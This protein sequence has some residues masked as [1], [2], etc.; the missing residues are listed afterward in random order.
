MLSLSAQAVLAD[1]TAV[2]RLH[3][4]GMLLLTYGEKK[5]AARSVSLSL[6]HRS[7]ATNVNMLSNRWT[8]AWTL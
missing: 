6:S 2:K 1:M 3:E 8:W 5:C 7:A 4:N